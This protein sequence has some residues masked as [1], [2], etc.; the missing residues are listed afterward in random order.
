MVALL[1]ILQA[2]ALLALIGLLSFVVVILYELRPTLESTLRDTHVTVLE[3]GLSAKNLREAS[4]EWKRA[5]AAQAQQATETEKQAAK[6]LRDLDAMIR[7]TDGS[8]N[9][10][11]LPKA[12]AALQRTSELQQRAS[13]DL[14]LATQRTLPALDNLG[15]ATASAA[16]LF[17]DPHIRESLVRLDEASTGVAISTQQL[18]LATTDVRLIADKFRDDYLKPAN[19][20]WA[21]FKALLGLG[22]EGR[23]LFAK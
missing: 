2:L 12:S 5:S 6:S 22:S 1:K 11:F 8:V 14:D 7:R 20:A 18:A 19:R 21:V 16:D 4:A 15:K 23:I 13:D 9:D 17:A 10:D 3:I